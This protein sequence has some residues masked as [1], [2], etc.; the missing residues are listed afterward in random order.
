[1]SQATI[2]NVP[3]VGPGTMDGFAS[4]CGPSFDAVLTNHSGASRPS[5]AVAG[6]TWLKIVSST[7]WEMYLFDG[8]DDLLI[9]T[10]N[11]VANTFISNS[12]VLGFAT[13]D[14]MRASVAPQAAANSRMLLKN[15]GSSEALL[16]LRGASSGTLDGSG[17]QFANGSTD[18]LL[19]SLLYQISTSSIR[20][21]DASSAE[22][23]R[24][25]LDGDIYSKLYGKLSE[26]I[27]AP[28]TVVVGPYASAPPGLV[29]ADGSLLARTGTYA[30]LWSFAQS[31]G[32]LTSDATWNTGYYGYFSTGDGSTTFRI[33]MLS[34]VF[35]RYLINASTWAW[36]LQYADNMA[37]H[38]HTGTTNNGGVD[39]THAQNPF[40][41]TATGSLNGPNSGVSGWGNSVPGSTQGASAYL[42]THSFTTA[43]TGSGS[44]SYPKNVG[45]AAFIKY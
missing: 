31:Y 13:S 25:Q 15:G 33:P 37:S 12:S 27:V 40:S 4:R 21:L 19:A 1:M 26:Q 34:N 3:L 24:L 43:A 36:G 41:V 38:T 14:V 8:T 18:A 10:F 39:H 20:V 17:V 2:F 23:M 45:L 32:L 29:R 7:A 11:P 35:I 16:W 44:E 6:T 28:G 42:H 22:S 5:Y 30:R 9:G